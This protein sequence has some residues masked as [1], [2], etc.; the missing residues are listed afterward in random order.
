LRSDSG[1][2]GLIPPRLGRSARSAGVGRGRRVAETSP[3]PAARSRSRPPSPRGEGWHRPSGGHV[4]AIRIHVSN[5]PADKRQRSGKCSAPGRRPSCPPRK[6]SRRVEAP[7]SAG[8]EAAAPG[9]HLAVRPVP[10]SEGTAGQ[11]RR[12]ARLAALH[13]GDFRGAWLHTRR[14][15]LALPVR[16]RRPAVQQAPCSRVV[17]PVKWSP[18]RPEVSG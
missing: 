11:L 7:Q 13:R 17:L 9:G 2:G 16:Y 15:T 3:H 8:A 5:S 14:A 1:A 6:Q 4:R 12:P 10:S 18:E